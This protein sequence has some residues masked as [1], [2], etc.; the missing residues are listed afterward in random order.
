MS[1]IYKIDE[2]TVSTPR[3]IENNPNEMI[4]NCRVIKKVF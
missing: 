2:N 1:R 4:S 3:S